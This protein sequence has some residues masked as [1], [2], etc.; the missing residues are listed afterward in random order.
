[1]LGQQRQFERGVKVA[2]KAL[3]LNPSLSNVHAWLAE[4]YRLLG[5]DKESRYH[6]TMRKRLA[7][8]E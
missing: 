3:E 1:M 2:K 7:P 4:T 8:S 5:N 6:D